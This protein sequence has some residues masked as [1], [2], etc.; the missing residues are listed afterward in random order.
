MGL[1]DPLALLRWTEGVL[2]LRLFDCVL[3]PA[4]RPLPNLDGVCLVVADVAGPG[5]DTRHDPGLLARAIER[6]LEGP[7]EVGLRRLGGE[8][9]RSDSDQGEKR[10]GVVQAK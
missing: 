9:C 8:V 3:W 2:G 4:S 6:C 1:L 7:G 5:G 10:L